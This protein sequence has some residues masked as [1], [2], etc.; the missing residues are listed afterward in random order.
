[1]HCEKDN[2]SRL[3]LGGEKK[4]GCVK[5]IFHKDIKSYYD[6]YSGQ[7]CPISTKTEMNFEA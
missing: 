3:W 4:A 5:R 2:R 1:M 6:E 7:L